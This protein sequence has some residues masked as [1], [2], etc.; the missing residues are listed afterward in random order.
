MKRLMVVVVALVFTL[1]GC[2]NGGGDDAEGGVDRVATTPEASAPVEPADGVEWTREFE[3]PDAM[4]EELRDS[5]VP[6]ETEEGSYQ[7]V[8]SERSLFCYVNEGRDEGYT[9][10]VYASGEQQGEAHVFLTGE[11]P[12]VKYVWGTGWSVAL[13]YASDGSE[14][15][16]AIGGEVG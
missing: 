1:A 5:G 8:Y 3:T 11:N 13:P 16:G 14:V 10:S 4:L 2:A 6:C 15:V 12:G 9:F 7:T